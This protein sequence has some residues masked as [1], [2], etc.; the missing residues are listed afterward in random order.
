MFIKINLDGSYGDVNIPVIRANSKYQ[1]LITVETDFSLR[2]TIEVTYSVIG[3]NERTSHGLL[4]QPDGTWKG[5]VSQK[6][7]GLIGKY[8]AGLVLM[9]FN[10]NEPQIPAGATDFLGVTETEPSSAANNGEFYITPE[11][12]VWYYLNGWQFSNYRKVV[13]TS[14]IEVPVDPNIEVDPEIIDLPE[15]DFLALAGRVA[16]NEYAIAGYNTRFGVVEAELLRLEDDKADITYVDNEDANTLQEAKDY[17]YSKVEIDN[18]DTAII[19]T[20]AKLA[21]SNVFTQ[22]QQVPNATL[23]QHT[24]NLSQV[25]TMFEMFKQQLRGYNLAMPDLEGKEYLGNG[26]YRVYNINGITIDYNVYNG[27]WTINGTSSAI[28]QEILF[29]IETNTEYTLSYI[30]VSG[31]LTGGLFTLLIQ[32]PQVNLIQQD[33]ENVDKQNTFI[34]TTHTTLRFFVN[35]DR[36]LDRKS[37][38]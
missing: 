7:L 15:Q 12:F 29:N 5:Y 10:I 33:D 38:V 18:K 20:T 11:G 34:T 28:T 1:H 32:S 4:A 24:T 6:A 35:V 36:T 16:V 26:V 9:S 22:P 14:S 13:T 37:V 27:I 30:A 23:P 3:T 8:K 2:N 25:E 19:D 21:E 31:T 17:T